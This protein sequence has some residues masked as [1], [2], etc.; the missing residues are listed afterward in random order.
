MESDK[1]RTKA[2]HRRKK[3]DYEAA[4][5]LSQ[6]LYAAFSDS[7]HIVPNSVN[8]QK[9]LKLKTPNFPS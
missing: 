2:I 7:K 3:P 8:P 9:P 4:Q 6:R 1:A 5:K